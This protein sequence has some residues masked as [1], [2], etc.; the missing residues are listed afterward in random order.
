MGSSENK[1]PIFFSTNDN[2]AKHVCV[3]IA[4][5]LDNSK[6][7]FYFCILTS[8][9]CEESKNAIVQTAAG[10]TVEFI[11]I[12]RRDFEN[13]N[14]LT[15]H[16]SIETCYRY[17]VADLK[18]EFDKAIYLDCDL[19]VLDDIKKMFDTDIDGFYAACSDEILKTSY[20]KNLGLSRYF[21]AGVLL[22]NCALMRRDNI[23][24]QLVR[25]TADLSGKLKYLDQDVLNIVF[26]KKLK[27]SHMRW[28]ATNPIFRK[29]AKVKFLKKIAKEARDNPAIVHFSGPD[30]PWKI[31]CGMLAH[32]YAAAYFY[33]LSKT[34][35]AAWEKEVF[36]NFNPLKTAL[37]Y[38]RRHLLFFLRPTF[39][40]MQILRS[41]ISGKFKQ[42]A[43]KAPK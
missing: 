27:F 32:P 29:S 30:K 43:L 28:N 36:D 37:W 7:E 41:K 38:W 13:F 3:A 35:Y 6:S 5:I 42:K 19:I 9:L 26:S 8:G 25:K 18:P 31:P 12:D 1:I 24:E 15:A 14:V 2:Y 23:T 40:K 39:W 22:L 16:I 21:N 20:Y 11:S 17:M 10:N 34:P 33:Y 4:S